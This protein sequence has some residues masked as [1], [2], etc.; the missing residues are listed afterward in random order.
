M[1][2]SNCKDVPSDGVVRTQ[3][4]Q[5]TNVWLTGVMKWKSEQ[6]APYKVSKKDKNNSFDFKKTCGKPLNGNGNLW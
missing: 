1:L 3:K 4:M 5:D 2:K 6:W